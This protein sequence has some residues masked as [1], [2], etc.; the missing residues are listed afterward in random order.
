MIWIDTETFSATP[1]KHGTYRYASDS[2]VLIVTYAFDQDPVQLWDVTA[3]RPMP[4]DLEY[5][6]KDSDDEIT[7]HNAMFDRIVLALSKNIKVRVPIARWRCTMARALAHS[8]PGSLDKLCEILNVPI[9]QRKLKTGRTLM[10]LFTQPRPKNSKIPR[11]TRY[12]HP[13]EWEQFCDY[14]T[15]DI[16][17]MRACAA[18]L[19]VWNYS[20]GEL[21]LWHL[22]QKINDRGF[23]VDVDFARAATR[24]VD[25]AQRRLSARAAELTQDAVA[26]TTQRDRLLA[27]ILQEYAVDLPDMQAS[28]IER[29]LR[30]PDLPPELR[31]L[32]AVRMEATTTSTSKYNALIRGA[33]NG[34][35]CGTKQFCGAGRTGR[36]G[37]RGF[38]PDNLPRPSHTQPE[39]VE[40]IDS[41]L[42]DCEDLIEGDVMG[43]A[44]S[45]IRGCIVA[46]PG[47]KLV[48][49]DLSNIEGRKAA[50]LAGEEWKLTAFRDFDAG[51]GTDTYKL[52][53]AKAFRMSPE[54]VTKEQRQ[55]GKVME[56]MLQYEGGVGAFVTGAATYGVDL[57]AMAAAAWPTLPGDVVHEAEGFLEW[58]RK[59][60]RPTFALADRTFIVC[61]SLKRLWRRAHPAIASY[62]PELKDTVIAAINEPGNTLPCRRLKVRCDGA[63]LR[64]GLPSGRAL[65]YPSPRVGEGNVI[66]Y[67]GVNQYTRAWARIKTYGGKL[68]ENVTQAASRDVLTYGMIEAEARHY[69]VVL[70]VHDELVTEVPE[71]PEFSVGD[72]AAI[73]AAP[74]PW[75]EGLPLAAS[76]FEARRY[77]KE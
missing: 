21:A 10:R 7:A 33:T 30:D 50:W 49:G 76:G 5:A 60:K 65:C 29:R 73:M 18:K 75:A 57:D 39:I 62:W 51:R 77:K 47:R 46:P 59:E 1:I 36:W 20:G 55:V 14:A 63:W 28:T 25:R 27:H 32:L 44:S 15:H 68:L 54:D 41:V 22:D 9:D 38:Q 43:L 48:V 45:A 67:M 64:I 37:G 12:T 74:I 56:L 35:L 8:L 11:A 66:S 42:A 53:Y 17:A 40:F 6:L 31:E 4:G 2:E 23:L 69:D 61:D 58:C 52:A 71:S 16:E 70:H 3:G 19:P 34:R 24:A 26:S 13:V 72:L